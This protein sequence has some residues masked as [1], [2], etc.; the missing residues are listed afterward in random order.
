MSPDL[1]RRKV[2]DALQ[3]LQAYAYH[4]PSCVQK[5]KLAGLDAVC[6]C[7]L[8]DLFFTLREGIRLL[9]GIDN[10]NPPPSGESGGST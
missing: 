10:T 4:N 5:Q 3:K 8:N 2:N 6:S 1:E 9:R 7:G